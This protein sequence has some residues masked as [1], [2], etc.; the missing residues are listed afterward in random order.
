MAWP[1]LASNPHFQNPETAKVEVNETGSKK[2]KIEVQDF[3][4]IPQC[5]EIGIFLQQ[6]DTQS[7]QQIGGGGRG[8]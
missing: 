8:G 2:F 5:E 6:N 3:N 4:V 7:K 1:R